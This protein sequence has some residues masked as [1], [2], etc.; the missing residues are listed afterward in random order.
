MNASDDIRVIPIRGVPIVEPGA[1]LSDLILNALKRSN[2]TLMQNDILAVC[3]KIVAKAEGRIVGLTDIQP[4]PLATRFAADTGKDPR[5][6]EAVLRE[7]KR[8]VKMD[9]GVLIAETK[10][11][12]VCANAGVD[13]SNVSGGDSV[14]LLPEDG[15]ASARALQDAILSRSGV[16]VAVAITDSFGRPWRL[17]QVDVAVGVAGLK[18]IEECEGEQD[19]MGLPLEQSQ[20]AV[21]DAIAAAAGLCFVKNSG[22]AACIMR[23]FAYV[24]GQGTTSELVRDRESDLFR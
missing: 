12:F 4:G 13:R 16:S 17:G 21:A 20:R 14:C 3:S 11:G 2:I 5:L 18:P 24:P 9:R 7:S 22:V 6:V 8:I 10:H 1:N 23:G 15:D 19:L